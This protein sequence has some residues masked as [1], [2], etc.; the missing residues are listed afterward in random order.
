MTAPPAILEASL[1]ADPAAARTLE[2]L[3]SL[4]T[5]LRAARD[6]LD[7]IRRRAAGLEHDTAW[8]A[9]AAREYRAG[10]AAW[11][12]RGDDAAAR[13]DVLDDELHWAQARLVMGAS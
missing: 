2:M 1:A 10:L 11:R 9:R 4:R 6:E 8:R 12:E 3:T 13:V 7:A 5:R